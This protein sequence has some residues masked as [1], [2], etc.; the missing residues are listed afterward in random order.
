MGTL[1]RWQSQSL[2]VHHQGG[3]TG[4]S[5]SVWKHSGERP[6]QIRGE[7]IG[8]KTIKTQGN[9]EIDNE[10]LILTAFCASETVV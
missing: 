3:I 8:K 7:G 5:G 9:L 10:I 1:I 6:G 4:F 2:P